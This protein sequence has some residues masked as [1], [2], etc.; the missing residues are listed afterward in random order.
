[1]A[2]KE[3][4]KPPA[5]KVP[6]SVA[7][8][9]KAQDTP[10]AKKEGAK[11]KLSA[12]ILQPREQFFLKIFIFSFT[13]LVVDVVMVH[14]VTN[15]LKHLDESI[16]TQEEVIPKRL[17]ILKH[18]DSILNE[19]RALKSFFVDPSL[20]QE[21]ETAQFLRQV[22]RVSKEVNFF[23]SNINP[24]K[25]TKISE[26][27]Y[28]LSLDVEGKGGPK[29][30]QNFIR[31]IEGT[32]PSIHVSAFNLKPQSKEAD[33]LKAVFSIIKMGVKKDQSATLV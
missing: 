25:V 27:V 1:M 32:D 6:A 33:E 19:Y 2:G 29:E 12:L 10:D 11:P 26:S 5:D 23:V 22:E 15:Y 31:T 20:S 21:E 16:K 4:P 17:M 30:I 24:V 7:D 14:P 28:Q 3:D 18:K 9:P 13:L 8:A